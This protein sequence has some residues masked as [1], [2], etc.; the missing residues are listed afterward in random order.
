MNAPG[1]LKVML[2]ISASPTKGKLDKL[3]QSVSDS[4]NLKQE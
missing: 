1:S 3:R 4:C 2:I